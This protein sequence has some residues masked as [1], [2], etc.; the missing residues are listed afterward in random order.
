MVSFSL[1]NAGL[2]PG[3]HWIGD[4]LTALKEGLTLVR[5]KQSYASE[6]SDPTVQAVLKE[7]M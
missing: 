6:Q 2:V 4:R 3:N 7:K 1:R 5:Q